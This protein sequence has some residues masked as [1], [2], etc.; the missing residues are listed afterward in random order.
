MKA[1]STKWKYLYA[2]V[3]LALIIQIVIYY[4]ITEHWS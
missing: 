3:I 2:A 4:L 1:E